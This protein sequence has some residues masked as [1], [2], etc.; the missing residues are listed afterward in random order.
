MIARTGAQPGATLVELLVVLVILSLMAS[1]ALLTFRMA[2]A[3]DQRTRRVTRLSEQVT[4][5]RRIALRS[6][7]PA[8]VA[9]DDS[10]QGYSV[11]A[12][13]DGSVVAD[14]ELTTILGIDRLPGHVRAVSSSGSGDGAR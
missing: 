10:A 7:R 3:P 12:L 9:I 5:A 6:G 2:S 11:T 1:T 8:T 14:S 13:P 4:E